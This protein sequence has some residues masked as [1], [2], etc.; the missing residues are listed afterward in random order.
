MN[1]KRSYLDQ[2]NAGRTR[3][4]YTTLDDLNRSLADLEQRIGRDLPQTRSRIDDKASSTQDRATT[5]PS[6]QAPSYQ[7]IA[8]DLQRVR[9]Q[10][11][12]MAAFGRIAQELQQLREELRQQVTS[13]MRREFEALRKDMGRASSSRDTG[14]LGAEFEKL[15][16]AVNALSARSDDKSINMLRLEIEQVK[17]ALDTLA[18]EPDIVIIVSA[19][20]SSS[21][22]RAP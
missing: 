7:A 17:N 11:D 6:S 13:G 19:G 16:S 4:P 8:R 2:L 10:E 12:G 9:S 18:R 21:G 22:D 20:N 15:S 3:R 1:S 5:Q 14:E